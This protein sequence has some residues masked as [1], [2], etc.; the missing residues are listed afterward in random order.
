MQVVRLQQLLAIWGVDV[1]SGVEVPPQLGGKA[2][3][4]VKDAGRMR[5]FV[6]AVKTES[7]DSSR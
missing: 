4:G 5:T 3:P 1:A 6:Q 2:S 7:D